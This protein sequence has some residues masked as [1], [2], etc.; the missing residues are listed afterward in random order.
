MKERRA[1][2]LVWA[3]AVAASLPSSVGA[4]ESYEGGTTQPSRPNETQETWEH[5]LDRAVELAREAVA[6]DD[7]ALFEGAEEVFLDILR[8]GSPTQVARVRYELGQLT[9]QFGTIGAAIT[10]YEAVQEADSSSRYAHQARRRLSALRRIA[11]EDYLLW[12]QFEQVRQTY[13]EL[14]SDVTIA[15]V[16]RLLEADPT[17]ELRAELLLWLGNEHLYV[18]GDW[19]A[20]R[21]FMF[22]VA[23]IDGLET[24]QYV[25]AF[26]GA[27]N[28]ADGWRARTEVVRRLEAFVSAHPEIHT[29]TESLNNLLRRVK[30]ERLR[31]IW[32]MIGVVGLVGVMAVFFRRR[33]WRAFSPDALMEWRPWWGMLVLTAL[34][35]AAA[36]FTDDGE[37][38]GG[39]IWACIPT[40][41][42]IFLAVRAARWTQGEKALHP[43]LLLLWGVVVVAA[44][45]GAVFFTLLFFGKPD[46]LGL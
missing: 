42:A 45:F 10:H 35:G 20:A 44:T 18:T 33:G 12:Q 32:T 29:E 40:L 26:L 28:A 21:Q 8:H 41:C 23:A 13:N 31:A 5:E 17:P 6:T 43:L 37:G 30:R 2:V 46:H 25:E 16:S 38:S 9:E 19:R 14:G 11:P 1:I 22:L 7:E 36:Y 3:M 4:T 39:P 15:E 24:P 34:F 27:V